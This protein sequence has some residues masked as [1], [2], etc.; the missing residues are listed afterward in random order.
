MSVPPSPNA[1]RR[2]VRASSVRV[3]SEAVPNS[4]S[5]V[6]ALSAAAVRSARSYAAGFCASLSQVE[7]LEWFVQR[8]GGVWTLTYTRNKFVR[9]AIAAMV[10]ASLLIPQSMS[11]ALLLGVPVQYGLYS[12]VTPT[13][14]YSVFTSVSCTQFGIVAPTSILSNG[15][16]TG[17]TGLTDGLSGTA[18]QNALFV[19]TQIQLAFACGVVF[20]VMLALRL[21]WVANFISLPVLNGFTWGS[22]CLIVAS[23][24]KDLFGYKP[25]TNPKDFGGRMKN[26]F[27]YI[28]KANVAAAVLGSVSLIILL[29]VKDVKIYGYALP[30]LTPVPLI[31]IVL[32]VIVSYALDLNG[33]YGVPIVGTIPSSL[34][35][36]LFPFD[37]GAQGASDFGKVIP[38]AILLSI[39]GFVQTLGVGNSF[40]G[41]RN[42][43]LVSWR[44]LAGSAAAHLGGCIFSSVTTSG[45]ITRTAVA[46]EAGA[47]SPMT[48]ILVGSLVL[49]A[50]KFLTPYL[51]Y[52]PMC[53]LAAVVT[54]S[55]RNLFQL[56][57]MYKFWRGKTSDFLTMIVTVVALLWL[58]VQ[59][60]LFIGIGFSFLSV[61]VRAFKPRLTEIGQLPGSDCYVAIDRFPEARR[62][63]GIVIFRLDGEMCFG[64]A[65][66]VQEQLLRSLR[67][68]SAARRADIALNVKFPRRSRAV[69]ALS[70]EDS[71]DFSSG[72][73]VRGDGGLSSTD[74]KVALRVVIF[75]CSRIVDMDANGARTL[76]SL[77]DTFRK[78]DI[79]LVLAAL[80]GPVRDTLERYGLED[81]VLR[82]QPAS[83][84]MDS[85][86]ASDSI[87]L[88]ATAMP[89]LILD[90]SNEV[91]SATLA[92]DALHSLQTLPCTR[93]LT[94][95][96]AV[97]ASK[98]FIAI[99]GAGICEMA[100]F[101]YYI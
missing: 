17:L 70:N 68:A 29:Y 86:R 61:L 13:I 60:G 76:I 84:T 80:P 62:A 66:D 65:P 85:A 6:A 71:S 64:N 87:E 35:P 42:E 34:P 40:V 82:V 41:K 36:Y 98:N 90:E 20:A 73:V 50:V 21:S 79:V 22:A 45:S 72:T 19:N 14:L 58:D 9:D 31:L 57:E 55:T 100:G 23:Q 49:I 28:G 46:F 8:R 10:T 24:L 44:E 16:G 67:D 7:L 91:A 26:A 25:A 99:K 27:D 5:S 101:D 18:T 51:R 54:S 77:V 2:T 52:L 1:P 88:D 33:T 83:A 32:A 63:P 95:A 75:D 96:A 3:F 93:F 4:L 47:A 59:Y 81:P 48:G 53:V 11:Y 37:V 94:V 78:R 69:Y 89:S 92:L 97:V 74:E 56:T 39:V 30:K 38:Q 12:A 15:I 43:V